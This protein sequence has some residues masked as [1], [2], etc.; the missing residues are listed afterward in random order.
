MER[1]KMLPEFLNIPF[2][3]ILDN[4]LTP[5]DLKV[6]GIILWFRNTSKLKM[7]FAKNSTI[8]LLLSSDNRTITSGSV[9]N[10]LARLEKFKYI[11]RKF[12][13]KE[14]KHRLEI[15][16]LEIKH[17]VSSNDGIG[18][19]Q[20]AVGVSSNDDSRVSSNDDHSNNK[21]SN[22]DIGIKA[23]TSFPKKILL[24]ILKWYLHTISKKATSAKL[25][26][27]EKVSK[28]I[29]DALSEY[30]PLDLLTAIQGFSN[31]TWQMEKNGFR[32]AEWFFSNSKRLGQY[33][34]MF[35]QNRDE[36]FI[37]KAKKFIKS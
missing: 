1:R 5:L 25:V 19:H 23:P 32:G 11:L 36:D 9:Q 33:I 15:I 28:S 37:K 20:M 21:K 4:N 2:T 13:D 18:Y 3:L 26:L 12:K 34:G 22:K 29:S 24:K 27:T 16:T 10:S 17:R 8:A 30:S 6:Y 14:K 35:N 31:D 7:C